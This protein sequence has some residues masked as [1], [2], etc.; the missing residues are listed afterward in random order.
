MTPT[1]AL[2]HAP[3]KYNALSRRKHAPLTPLDFSEINR[4]SQQLADRIE[5]SFEELAEI[6]LEYESFEVVQDETN[7]TLDLLLNLRENKKYFRLRVG[8]VSAFLPRNQPLYAL[9]CFV[10]VPSLMASEVH[11]RIP[12]SMRH[13]F[14]KLLKLLDIHQSF[15]NVIV[16]HKERL[17]FLR[18]R[19]A[20]RVNPKTQESWP[21]TDAVIFTGTSNH[22]DRLRLVFDNRTLFIANGAG[23]N[24]IVVSEDADVPRAVE[25]TL[26]LQL[27]NQGQDC[28]APNAILV[29]KAVFPDFLR[30]LHDALRTVRV[31]QYS[32]R[33]CRVGPISE[34]E[35]L[36]RIQS[37]LIEHRAWIDPSSP[38][39]IRAHD[40]I[41]EPTIISKPLKEGGN[42]TEVFAPIIFLQQYEEDS[43]LALY[44]ESPHYARNAMYISVYGKSAY[45]DNLIGRSIGGKVFHERASVIH[46]MHLHM[47]G[48]ERGTQPYGG[49]GYSASS[50]SINGKIICKPT[51]PQRDIYEWIA[52]PL[53]RQKVREKHKAVLRRVTKIEHKDVQK[54]LGMKLVGISEKNAAPVISTAYV[55]SHAIKG[56]GRRYVRVGMEHTFHLLERPNIEHIAKLEPKDLQLIRALRTFLQR[57][58]TMPMDE[59]TSWLYALAKKPR[60]AE[61]E[62]RARQLRFFGHLY[63]LLLGKESGPRLAHFL[64]DADRAK[65]CELLDV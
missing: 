64:L 62:N 12:N 58:P 38:G 43:D 4:R 55:D 30:L 2:K 6:L 53:L 1:Q 56:E 48:V 27:Y 24:P 42:F 40:A 41:L 52:K 46:N 20:L 63:N 60:A 19:S 22:A 28:A 16:S 49:C 5:S 31:G 13:F 65:I 37:L 14:P 9:T 18:E 36:V 26:T 8:P 7:R 35:D 25:A 45:I 57:Q 39:I 29:H 17:E 32:D 10:I 33:S 51:L 23:H 21:V 59:F 44:F 15:P 11:F 50:L 54:L 34:P 3:A 61:R 47:P